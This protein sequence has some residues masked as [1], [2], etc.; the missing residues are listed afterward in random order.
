LENMKKLSNKENLMQQTDAL[1]KNIDLKRQN[2]A[3]M[4]STGLSLRERANDFGISA[5]MADSRTAYAISL[6]A[7]IS[8][9]TWDYTAPS[10]R[11]VG[12]MGNEVKKEVQT[13]DIDT[14]ALTSYELA[15]NL[16]DMIEANQQ[17][18]P[19]PASSVA[20]MSSSSGNNLPAGCA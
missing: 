4:A 5:E 20:P 19:I 15:N 8:N 11:L 14:R 13:F 16:W 6:Y 12:C 18:Q 7:K 17:G 10:G 3:K 2:I 1:A 9:I